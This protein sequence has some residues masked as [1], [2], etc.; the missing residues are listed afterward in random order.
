MMQ[1]AIIAQIAITAFSLTYVS[2]AHWTARAF[3]TFSL[4]SSITAVYYVLAQQRTMGRLVHPRQV[5]A[6]IRLIPDLEEPEDFDQDKRAKILW[7]QNSF[8]RLKDP[9]KRFSL[10]AQRTKLSFFLPNLTSV[11]TVSAPKLLL[12]TSIS[13]FLI[14][15]GV[16]IGS[17][18]KRKLD[19]DAG[20]HSS[21]AI[22]IV[23][24]VSVALCYGVYI[25]CQ[26]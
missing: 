18:W 22:F 12:S 26:F 19:N 23:Y 15:L 9:T 2:Q 7:L 5:R 14:G 3:F 20:V 4:I 21:K 10:G 13:A 24:L 25:F 1:G 6:W 11:L 8:S 16:Y 17:V